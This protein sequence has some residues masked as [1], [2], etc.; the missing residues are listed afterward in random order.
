MKLKAVK[1]DEVSDK[2]HQSIIHTYN[3]NEISTKIHVQTLLL[4][5]I[6]LKIPK[7]KKI[8][9]PTMDCTSY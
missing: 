4:K 7:M 5:R 8:K 9:K 2:V 1:T 6:R 3:G